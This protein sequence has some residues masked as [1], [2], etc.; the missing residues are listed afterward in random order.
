MRIRSTRSAAAAALLCAGSTSADS[1]E[2]KT[3]VFGEQLQLCSGAGMALTGFMRDGACT[4]EDDDVGSHHIC[5]DIAA[6]IADGVNFCT[7]TGQSDWC[8]DQ[9]P[10]HEDMNQSCDVEKWCVCQWAF[11]EYIGELESCADSVPLFCDATNMEAVIAYTDD[12]AGGNSASQVAL[13]CL[14]EK[15][16]GIDMAKLRLMRNQTGA[17]SNATSGASDQKHRSAVAAADKKLR[18]A[19]QL[20]P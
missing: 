8:E 9:M 12:V 3:N 17:T 15:C 7:Q 16:P 18:G 19:K 20:S 6:G 11:E 4:E 5:I 2:G 1:T 14:H 13:D 10:C